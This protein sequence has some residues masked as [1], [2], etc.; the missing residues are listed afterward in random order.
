MAPVICMIRQLRPV[1]RG[2]HCHSFNS[3][4]RK[5]KGRQMSREFG[6]LFTRI[7]SARESF[8]L[9]PAFFRNIR[10]PAQRA[11]LFPHSEPNHQPPIFSSRTP[12]AA[13]RLG[14]RKPIRGSVP[15][16]L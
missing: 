5:T 9:K 3:N 7:N 1:S 10:H 12:N 4:I 8:Q 16:P 14:Q 13:A 6:S 15:L 2:G 11:C